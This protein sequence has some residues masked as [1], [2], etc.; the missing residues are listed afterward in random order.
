MI[1]DDTDVNCLAWFIV[2]NIKIS[3]SQTS[4]SVCP[5]AS[6]CMT[7]ALNTLREGTHKLCNG[8]KVTVYSGSTITVPREGGLFSGLGKS[9]DLFSA[10]QQIGFKVSYF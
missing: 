2:K 4:L 8:K 10:C 5:H 1:V 3:F 7:E 6:L 9:I